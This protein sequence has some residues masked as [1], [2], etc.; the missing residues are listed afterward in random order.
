MSM[1]GT[2]GA[3]SQGDCHEFI[4]TV[5]DT[6]TPHRRTRV[7]NREEITNQ[8]NCTVA[9]NAVMIKAPVSRPWLPGFAMPCHMLV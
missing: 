4:A 2:T 8:K 6:E 7:E 1:S 5:S 9:A 3:G